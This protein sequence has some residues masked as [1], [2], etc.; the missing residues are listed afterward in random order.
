VKLFD[1]NILIYAHR[2]DQLHHDFYRNRLEQALAGT[3][4]CGLTVAV[5]TGFV[6]IVTQPNFP[7][8]PTP[9][10]Q[11]LAVI[12]TLVSPGGCQ[13]VHPASGH[14]KLVADLCRRTDTAGKSVSDASHA[15]TAI[16][17]GCTWISRDSDFARF[18]P[19]GLRWERWE[20]NG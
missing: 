20:E 5:A 16:E 7:H 12:E 13:W 6:R 1:T 15:A 17:H 3:E 14:W 11:A 4:V 9:L 2:A 10:P 18:T 19:Y 8:G